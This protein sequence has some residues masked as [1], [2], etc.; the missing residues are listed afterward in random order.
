M[1]EKSKAK[2]VS[3]SSMESELIS[4]TLA[5]KETLWLINLLP[6]LKTG[7]TSLK[8]YKDNQST[9]KYIQ[10]DS[11]YHPRAKHISIKYH[12]IKKQIENYQINFE[13]LQTSDMA[14]DFLTKP[15]SHVKILSYVKPFLLDKEKVHKMEE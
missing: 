5:L 2:C 11:N 4:M 7:Y 3:L 8:I 12:F 15:L 6:E 9:I 10:N 1:L 14:A 13:Y